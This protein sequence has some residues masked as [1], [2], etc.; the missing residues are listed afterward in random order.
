MPPVRRGTRGRWASSEGIPSGGVPRGESEPGRS[1]WC[2]EID[3]FRTR[4]RF[5]P[6]PPIEYARWISRER[7]RRAVPGGLGFC[8]WFA[9]EF[10]ALLARGTPVSAGRNPASWRDE[11]AHPWLSALDS[12]ESLV[13]E[14]R[15]WRTE[16]P[17]FRLTPNSPKCTGKGDSRDRYIL[18][19]SR[20][21]VA[22]ETASQVFEIARSSVNAPSRLGRYPLVQFLVHFGT[23]FGRFV[24]PGPPEGLRLCTSPRRV[25]GH[26]GDAV[27]RDVSPGAPSVPSLGACG[28]A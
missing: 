2:L 11:A 14:E 20:M 12:R 16:N 17:R 18:E 19:P 24:V 23:N 27:R 13:S 4:V 26:A 7:A 6:P 28:R 9:G 22:V 10:S 8:G 5:P 25:H 15:N 21:L 3:T 1:M